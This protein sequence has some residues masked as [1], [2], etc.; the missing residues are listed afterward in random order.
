MRRSFSDHHRQILSFDPAAASAFNLEYTSAL[1]A[2]GQH[3]RTFLIIAL[4][5]TLPLN[6]VFLASNKENVN[7]AASDAF[8]P[9]GV[10]FLVWLFLK[11]RLRL[12]MVSLCVLAIGTTVLSILINMDISF[13]NK[14]TIGMAV[15]VVKVVGLWL[16][17]YIFCNLIQNRSDF[18]LLVK[19]WILGS[20]VEGLC[21]IGGSLAYQVAGFETPFAEM[22]RAQGT[23]GDAN[24]FATHLAA[25]FFLTYLYRR[26]CRAAPVWTIPAMLVQ[27]GG[28]YFSA[29]RGGLLSFGASI[30]VL[31]FLAF[32][33]RQKLGVVAGLGALIL[34]MWLTN[35]DGPLASNPIT[36]RLKTSTVS[37]NDP[38]AQQRAGLWR[39]ALRGF[40]Q[41]PILG[42][43]RGNF[44][45][46]DV[47]EHL[48]VID[49]QHGGKA[50][51][52]YLEILCETGLCGFFTYVALVLAVLFVLV[53]DWLRHPDS[54]RRAASG[55][56][57]TVL[58]VV[59]L[60]G[61]TISIENYRG[62][63]ILLALVLAYQQLYLTPTPHKLATAPAI[64]GA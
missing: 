47:V 31:W 9:L 18:R 26:L 10:I 43:G 24:L 21:G 40:M 23:L 22:F 12:P 58:V 56:L 39:G 57:F 16:Y 2:S 19:I 6:V 8:V 44:A 14:G 27:L 52:T 48:D 46:L 7:L 53:R 17:F 28:I 45:Y 25:S 63:W 51:N 54:G 55:A 33:G 34:A 13:L 38:E 62:L 20:I 41:S 49:S 35:T 11:G 60:N 15:E 61:V 3:L 5:A 29:S 36:E 37:L 59:G 30:V 50:H 4:V 64:V 32:S 1:T 42:I